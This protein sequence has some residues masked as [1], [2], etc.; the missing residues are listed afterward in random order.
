[1]TKEYKRIGD[2]RIV[3]IV[4]KPSTDLSEIKHSYAKL[5]RW[6]NPNQLSGCQYGIILAAQC[7]DYRIND[8]QLYTLPYV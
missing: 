7:N 1:M 3:G 2:E 4:R 5:P 6:K 8:F